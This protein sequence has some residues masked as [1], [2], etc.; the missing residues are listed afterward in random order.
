MGDIW[1][2]KLRKADMIWELAKRVIP[3]SPEPTGRWTDVHY[4]ENAQKTLEEC[5][6]I[7]E[8]VFTKDK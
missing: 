1:D 7:I 4:L 2:Y 6:K 3:E 8:A 5:S